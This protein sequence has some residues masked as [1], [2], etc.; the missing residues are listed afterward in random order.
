[1]QVDV[2]DD[3]LVRLIERV[4]AQTLAQL[5]SNLSGVGSAPKAAVRQLA[6]HEDASVAAPVLKKSNRL[7]EQDLAEIANTRGQRHLLAISG[8]ETLNESLSDLLVK[9]GDSA[10]RSTLA[11][12]SGAR[13]SGAGYAALV[14]DAERD[15]SLAEKLGLR[16][17]IPAELLRELVAKAT[18][19]VR[20]R[21]LKSASPEMQERIRAAVAK[22]AEQ[23]HV[24][25][26]PKPI[27]YT[28][29]RS[30]M[31]QLNRTGKL[32]DTTV[33]RFAVQRDY[34]DVVA[35]ISFLSAAAIGSIE[36]LMR[37]ARLDGLIVACKAA[38]LNWATTTMI[39]RN[40][41]GCAPVSKQELQQGQEVFETLSLSAAQH[42]IQFWS[43][44]NMAKKNDRS[45]TAV[46]AIKV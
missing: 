45:N 21:L 39:I 24:P 11:Q 40:R 6:F 43:A 3:V 38:R 22:V 28:E 36:P 27:D 2:F 29:S 12:N 42:T 20:T 7:S 35:A 14:Q 26:P 10:V 4:E 33:N 31:I 16:A 18:D 44:Q 5:S 25:P 23:V 46:A 34:T 19:R 17:D 41:P 8:R 13:L 9:R 30:K 37:N 32:N 1:M 15:D